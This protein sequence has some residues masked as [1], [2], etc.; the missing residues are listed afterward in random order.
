MITQDASLRVA[1]SRLLRKAI[2]PSPPFAISEMETISISP[3][4]C[5]SPPRNS[6]ISRVFITQN[7]S[8]FLVKVRWVS[9]PFVLRDRW[10]TGGRYRCPRVLC[11]DRAPVGEAPGPLRCPGNQGRQ[12]RR[13]SIGRIRPTTRFA[14][15]TEH[16]Q[17]AFR[18]RS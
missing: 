8:R 17:A 4:P 18:P 2:S 3:L 7:Y 11:L 14:Q 16:H 10:K 6:A 9:L 15:V 1:S 12:D 5:S 13:L